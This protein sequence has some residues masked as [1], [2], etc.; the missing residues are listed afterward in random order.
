MNRLV[1]LDVYRG[2]IMFILVSNGLGI[3]ALAVYPDWQWLAA[4][5]EHS[6]WTGI[7]FW[8]LIQPAFT[9]MVG[10]AMPFSLARRQAQGASFN[11][12]FRHVC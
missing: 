9:F 12:L 6:D 4:Q 10:V 7:T 8:D 2:M 11:D 1:S 5:F 3:S